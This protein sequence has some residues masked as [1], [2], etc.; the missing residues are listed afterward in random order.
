MRKPVL[1]VAVAALVGAGLWWWLHRSHDTPVSS[2]ATNTE[3]PRAVPPRGGGTDEPTAASA[4]LVEAD[5]SGDPRLSGIVLDADENPVGAA[6]VTL[7][8]NPPREATTEADGG[9]V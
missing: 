4:V 3:R 2:P 6:L 5:P 8:P 9:F 7:G 1:A